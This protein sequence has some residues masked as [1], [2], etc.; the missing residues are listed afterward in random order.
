METTHVNNAGALHTRLIINYTCM[1]C[2][3][4]SSW[5]RTIEVN[6]LYYCYS[7][8]Y[9]GMAFKEEQV[10]LQLDLF[11]KKPAYIPVIGV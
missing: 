2:G 9:V 7:C 11:I 10:W 6:K 4:P 3:Y 5:L 1:C 8:H